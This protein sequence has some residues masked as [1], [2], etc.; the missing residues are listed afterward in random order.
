MESENEKVNPI[1]TVEK[2]KRPRIVV[3]TDGVRYE[4]VRVKIRDNNR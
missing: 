4:K 2:K 3:N 1:K